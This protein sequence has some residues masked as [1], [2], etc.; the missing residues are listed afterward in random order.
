MAPGCLPAGIAPT[1]MRGPAGQGIKSKN[2]PAV[3]F[4]P[5]GPPSASP[6]DGL[7]ARI[8]ARRIRG[9]PIRGPL[10]STSLILQEIA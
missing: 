2:R 4:S 5:D 9:G 10:F 3:L 1:I 8:S 7:P 6:H